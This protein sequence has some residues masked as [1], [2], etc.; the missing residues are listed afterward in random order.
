MCMDYLR[1][2]VTSVESPQRLKVPLAPQPDPTLVPH[3]ESGMEGL[4][5]GGSEGV[6]VPDNVTQL[7]EGQVPTFV[8][9]IYP[10]LLDGD[11]SLQLTRP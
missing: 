1:F 3:E 10:Q 8:I 7:V 11:L 5:E 9:Q 6:E 2:S 4:G